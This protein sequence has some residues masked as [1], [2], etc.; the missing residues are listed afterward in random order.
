MKD[1][2]VAQFG[3]RAK[4]WIEALL[5]QLWESPEILTLFID[6]YIIKECRAHFDNKQPTKA[7]EILEMVVHHLFVEHTA[8]VSE[9]RVIEI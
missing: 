5:W 3:S 1:K 7:N 4:P 6:E 2:I 8:Q 9:W